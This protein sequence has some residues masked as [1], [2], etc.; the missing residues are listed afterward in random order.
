MEPTG[1][2]LIVE[3]Q[4]YAVHDARGVRPVTIWRPKILASEPPTATGDGQISLCVPDGEITLPNEQ[5]IAFFTSHDHEPPRS[6]DV[7]GYVTACLYRGYGHR[8]QK[9]CLHVEGNVVQPENGLT[10]LIDVIIHDCRQGIEYPVKKALIGPNVEAK[11]A[12]LYRT[13]Q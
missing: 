3:P 13:K 6:R 12:H 5:V 2:T 10:C 8:L 11:N 4:V 7:Q 1:K 9:S